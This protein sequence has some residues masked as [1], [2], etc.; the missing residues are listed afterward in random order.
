MYNVFSGPQALREYLSPDAH[1]PI[2]LVELPPS[3]NPYAHRGVRVYVKCMFLLPL[4]NIKSLP[5]LSMLTQAHSTGALD[6][7][8]TMI[9]NSS[10]NTV[11][12]LAVLGR[13]FSIP[14]T[15]AIVSHEVSRGKLALLRLF[16]TEIQVNEE[17]ICPDPSDTTSGIYKAREYGM[18]PGWFNPGQYDNPSNPGAHEAV[19]GP[20]LYEQLGTTLDILC[21]GLGTTGTLVGTG[22]YLRKHI[23]DLRIIGVVRAPNNP[24]PGV[25]TKN[26]LRQIAFPWES[27]ATRVHTVGTKDAFKASLEL[28]RIG[29]LAGPSSG[30]ALAGLYAELAALDEA[31]ELD[32]Y[33]QKR[34][35]LTAVC[36]CPDGPLP[37][38]D[39]YFEYLD[40]TDFPIIEN[41]EL[42]A[43][44]TP[45]GTNVA[46]APTISVSDA[47]HALYK[48][49]SQ[50]LRDNIVLLDVRGIDEFTDAHLHG[51]THLPH[52]DA[53]AQ[54]QALA[55]KYAGVT[56]YTICRSGKRSALVTAALHQ[57]GIR[58]YSIEGGMI[59]WSELNLPRV[60]PTI[61]APRSH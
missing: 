37:Y 31:R 58:S 26:L 11:Y 30:F 23:P 20:Q 5:A 34:G 56:V 51:A 21:A 17:P 40:P 19:T 28:I 54:A 22:T 52:T 10:G 25:R 59:A 29:I 2:P 3:L 47:H 41:E 15:R 36:V 61:C 60:Q 43:R 49:N 18:Q 48:P 13:L 14:R 45:G 44:A 7:V 8:D 1:P 50:T 32:S 33:I 6:G 12:S 42:L 55:T 57:Y 35:S 46:T 4:G 9:E 16:G 27:T 53:L 38:V 39:E 24:V